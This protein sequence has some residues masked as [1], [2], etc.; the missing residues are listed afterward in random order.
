MVY[1][2]CAAHVL[3]LLHTTAGDLQLVPAALSQHTPVANVV[4]N[5]PLGVAV[6]IGVAVAV[7]VGVGT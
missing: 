4:Q 7:G 2:A 1:G 3:L 5:D 6:A